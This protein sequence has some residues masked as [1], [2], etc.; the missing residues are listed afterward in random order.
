MILICN[1]KEVKKIIKIGELNIDDYG[2]ADIT[3][4]YPID[5]I[6]DSKIS[7]DK[8][9]GAAIV[10][11]LDSNI[12]SVMSGFASTDI[13]QWKGFEMVDNSVRTMED[14][15][16]AETN[17]IF[18]EYEKSI[19][20][21]KAVNKE[22]KSEAEQVKRNI[23]ESETYEDETKYENSKQQ[24]RDNKNNIKSED[25]SSSINNEKEAE[26][27]EAEVEEVEVERKDDKKIEKE[28]KKENITFAGDDELENR[29]INKYP[30]GAVGEFFRGISQGLEEL[31]ELS[32]EIKKCT[33]YK[34]DIKNINDMYNC[35]DYNKYTVL[36]YPMISYYPYIKQ[37]GHYILGYKFNNEGKMKYLVYGVP[38]KKCRQEQPYGGKSGFVTWIPLKHGEEHE[39]SMGY[40]LMFYDFRNST[41]I[42]PV[43]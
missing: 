25:T 40:W 22:D 9:S 23:N 31:K 20:E 19:E 39:D 38:G 36:Y 34:V 15:K 2:R 7:M 8:I 6:C 24:E 10:K 28:A 5:S 26:V 27:E 18:D 4:E 13:P 30:L 32:H 1:K 37:Y 21:V 11:L 16:P 35:A 41:I 29:N 3:Y 14:D 42:I 17:S 12:I 33:W 43:K